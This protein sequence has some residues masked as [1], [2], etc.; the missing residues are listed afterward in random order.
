MFIAE[1]LIHIGEVWRWGVYSNV[2][3]VFSLESFT[4]LEVGDG[5][6]VST[7]IIAACCKK[8]TVSKV[9]A[10]YTGSFFFT[11]QYP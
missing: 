8:L 2:W 6:T 3:E 11:S 10:S 1:I 7:C 4:S 5:L 9:I